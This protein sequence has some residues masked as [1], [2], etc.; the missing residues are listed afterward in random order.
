M[1][2]C[3]ERRSRR[4]A[5]WRQRDWSSTAAIV[6]MLNDSDGGVRKAALQT[7]GKLEAVALREHAPW[8]VERL[9]HGTMLSC[10]RRRSGL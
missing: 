1:R 3:D 4:L 5:S 7:L 10:V 2:R 6:T 9:D 8:I